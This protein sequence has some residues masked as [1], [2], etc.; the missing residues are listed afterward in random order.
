MYNKY[1]NLRTIK[2]IHEN[3]INKIIIL[4]NTVSSKTSLIHQYIN[5]YIDYKNVTRTVI[6]DCKQTIFK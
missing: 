3:Y 1:L 6:F 2:M 5:G 4:F